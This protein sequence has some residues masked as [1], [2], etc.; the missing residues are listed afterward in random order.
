MALPSSGAISLANV[1]TNIGASSTAPITMND[2]PVRW[3]A[4][5][6]AAAGSVYMNNL[7]GKSWSWTSNFTS[8]SL[9]SVQAIGSD[10]NGF[11]YTLGF[12]AGPG[13][14]VVKT[15]PVGTVVWVTKI[16]PA[17]GYTILGGY[18]NGIGVSSSGNCY[19]GLLLYRS[20]N[21][22]Y[23]AGVVK[24]TGAGVIG[25]SSFLRAPAT[26]G[27]NGSVGVDSNENVYLRAF[28]DF[29]FSP[30][31]AIIAKWNSSGTLQWQKYISGVF[32]SV[33][34]GSL[35]ADYNS[36]NVY[37]SGIVTDGTNGFLGKYD[38][39]LNQTWGAALTNAAG[40]AIHS[41]AVNPSNSNV[42]AAVGSPATGIAKYNSS[43]TLQWQKQFSNGSVFI[44]VSADS[45]D[46]AYIQMDPNGSTNPY[47]VKVNSSGSIVGQL[48]FAPN[49]ASFGVSNNMG[50]SAVVGNSVAVS[51]NTYNPSSNNGA[52][53]VKLLNGL[54]TTGTYGRVVISAPSLTVSNT[55][56]TAGSASPTVG[57][58]SY[59][60]TT[61]LVTASDVTGSFT[62][63][64]TLI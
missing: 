10:S 35:D 16:S 30:G 50:G 31:R 24:V 17:S 28:E 33:G 37:I 60:V 32:G 64:V 42:Y 18:R 47:L 4:N 34:Y 43:G 15:N 23:E 13:L 12:S 2:S 22:T 48:Q 6:S 25:W 54:T 61:S 49:G 62:K 21:G 52:S 7:R 26:L 29:D 44:S 53:T 46:N 40:C 57:T 38:E 1:N 39:N 59:T 56:Y 55:S 9:F 41:V 36:T 3:L 19:V 14:H 20:S 58:S 63:T 27:E 45:S 5:G 51:L 11:I 8:G